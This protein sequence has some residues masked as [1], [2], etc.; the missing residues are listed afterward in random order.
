MT[1]INTITITRKLEPYLLKEKGLESRANL[2]KAVRR[3]FEEIK[4]EEPGVTGLDVAEISFQREQSGEIN[5][6]FYFK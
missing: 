5:L 4:K 2:L 6:K 1:V 3:A